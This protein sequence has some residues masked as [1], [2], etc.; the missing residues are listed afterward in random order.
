MGS[1][2]VVGSAQTPSGD[3][4][5]FLVRA[6]STVL[7]DLGLPPGTVTSDA[8]GIDAAGDIV[9]NAQAADGTGTAWLFQ[10]GRPPIPLVAKGA[11]RDTF[12]GIHAAAISA[13][14]RAVGWAVLVSDAGAVLHCIQWTVR[15]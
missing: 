9:G 6:G 3:R 11:G 7:I 4:H 12:L 2:S 5:A 8:R 10:A 13:T 14:G 15:P 1:T